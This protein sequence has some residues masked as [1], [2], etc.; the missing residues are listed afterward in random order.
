MAIVIGWGACG[1]ALGATVGDIGDHGTWMT[2]YNADAIVGAMSRDMGEFSRGAIAAT[3][4]GF[5]P[6]EVRV[7]MAFV[8][9]MSLIGDVLENSLVRF[10]IIFIIVAYA[11][12]ILFETYQMMRE[13]QKAWELFETVLKK[14]VLITVW[15]MVLE[16]GPAQLFMWIVGPIVAFATAM[17]DLILGAVTN[18]AGVTLPDTCGAV[19]QYVAANVG[20][21]FVLDTDT[22]ANLMCLPTRMSGFFYTAI[23]TGWSWIVA[24]IG[25]SVMSVVA[26]GALVFVFVY[27][28][29]KFALMA[30]GVIADLFLALF[31]LPFT[32]VAET[33]AK[34]KYKG[35]AGTIFNG[36]LDLFHAENLSKQ[37]SRFLNAAIY[38]V[39]LAIV[40]AVCAALMSGLV[41][42]GANGMPVIGNDDY[43]AV[44]LG[45][46]L[47]AYLVRRADKLAKDI[48]GSIDDTISKKFGGD[49]K[50]L[51]T[52]G[53]KTA[54]K[55]IN[56]M[57]G[58]K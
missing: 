4:P 9:A 6:I 42:V 26:G 55:W 14:G 34:T 13:G 2:E 8:G 23:A 51:W 10:M 18:A 35:I 46:I 40:I 1:R 20:P 17:A 12:W 43:L 16:F 41:T 50:N 44:L 33:I 45:G 32:A 47:V 11:F 5:V 31:M 25:H 48:G 52:Q 21:G 38:F 58:K 57:R 39:S 37:I 28:M 15:I 56:T 7:G 3:Q 29:W 54:V 22:M 49:M 27:N 53:R 36:F 24:G 30:L 19:H